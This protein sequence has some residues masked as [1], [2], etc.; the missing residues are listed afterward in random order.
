M[1]PLSHSLGLTWE[2]ANKRRRESQGSEETKWLRN[3]PCPE[4]LKLMSC[5]AGTGYCSKEQNLYTRWKGR[6]PTECKGKCLFNGEDPKCSEKGLQTDCEGQ[7]GCRWE[8]HDGM[9]GVCKDKCSDHNN[10]KSECQRQD[11]NACKWDGRTNQN[12][13][14]YKKCPDDRP[15]GRGPMCCKVTEKGGN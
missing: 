14:C 5:A 11:G 12:G 7:T 2:E 4:G 13:L 9:I 6:A 10:D 3:S 1:T 8:S 15:R